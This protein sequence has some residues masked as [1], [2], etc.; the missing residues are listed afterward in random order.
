MANSANLP[1]PYGGMNKKTPIAALNSPYCE[2][3]INFN[4]TDA[5][6]ELRH[7]DKLWTAT[8]NVSPISTDFFLAFLKYGELKLFYSTQ[9]STGNNR[10]FDITTSTPTL[11]Y[12]STTVINGE[13]F[14]LYFNK[15][16]YSFGTT[17][18]VGDVYNGSTWGAWGWSFPSIAPIGGCA[19]K[20]RAY[21]V[22]RATAIFGYG[23]IDA[24]TGSVTE[25]DLS[26]VIL[27][28]SYLSTIAPITI[29]SNGSTLQLLA[30]VFFSGEVLFY[31]GSY[32][33]SDS[34]SL[35]G[36]GKIGKPLNYNCSI[37]Y[38]GDALVMTRIGLVS[39]RDVFL[40]GS[41]QATIKTVSDEINP[42]WRLLVSELIASILYY[43]ATTG[44]ISYV[45]GAWWT[46]KDRIVISFPIKI[47]SDGTTALGT[48]YFVFDTLRGGWSIH[49]TDNPT[50][51][52]VEFQDDIYVNGW[53]V[54][55]SSNYLVT[56]KKE[57]A[58]DLQDAYNNVEKKDY[59]YDFLSAP[60][61]FP[62][63]SVTETNQIEPI[64]ESDLYGQTNWSF[65]SDFGKQTTNN[66]T[67][68]AL[69]TVSKPAVNV[70]IQNITYVQVRMS[71]T[72]TSGKTVGLKLY[73]YNVWF[74]A[75]E[76]ASR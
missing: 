67:T 64:L 43:E 61:P 20:N 26:G 22:G 55:D 74:D 6:I 28:Q 16:L 33:D 34:W 9:G 1:A 63:T 30:Y 66:Q 11:A 39:L 71:G 44:R 46:A 25:K 29:V 31:A 37:D 51:G 57:A 47:K 62:K 15:N 75:G 49:T 17:T 14:S 73:S 53:T 59:D 68:N 24:I 72:T 50:F 10:Y 23:G 7:G 54:G 48:T 42:V 38:Q 56:L 36:R 3:L 18:S 76:T 19:F 45:S 41:Q 40:S 35:I 70:G 52:L 5:G 69:S 2:N 32:P 58:D 13:I 60:I 21:F 12:T 65:V 4:T 8:K 27:Q